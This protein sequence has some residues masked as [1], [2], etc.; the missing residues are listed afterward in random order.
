[1][2]IIA[3][4]LLLAVLILLA[5]AVHERNAAWF[6]GEGTTQQKEVRVLTASDSEQVAD[7]LQQ[8]IERRKMM[9]G[10]YSYS[11]VLLEDDT[12]KLLGSRDRSRRIYP[13]SMTKMMT[14][15][16]VLEEGPG[17]DAKLQVPAGLDGL[18]GDDDA[19]TAGISE[20]EVLSER[21]LLYGVLLPSGADCC[22]TLAVD[23]FG[24]EAAFAERMNAKAL[25]LGMKDTHFV[26]TTGLHNENHY[27]TVTDM[28]I[29]LRY[30]MQNETF[31]QMVATPLYRT[32]TT[33]QHPE[34]IPLQS[35]IFGSGLLNLP[36]TV[37]FLGGKTGYTAEAGSCL[38]SSA[39]IGGKT[40]VLVTAGAGTTEEHQHTNIEDAVTVYTYLA[41]AAS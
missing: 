12:G 28:A 35:T 39:V 34:G 1:M 8:A 27:S 25:E 37:R 32:E 40:Y 36:D 30:A 14:A 16:V 9:E 21:D 7:F 15:L 33:A 6:K 10:L 29:L 4:V 3:A 18:I 23:L 24:N 31:A 2:R 19:S 11:C 5:A 13:A 38:A 22:V 41:A 17:L 26:N 20:G